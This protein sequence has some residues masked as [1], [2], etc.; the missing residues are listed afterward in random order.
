MGFESRF[1]STSESIIPIPR[2]TIPTITIIPETA[3]GMT[4]YIKGELGFVMACELCGSS[5]NIII[6][7]RGLSA[8]FL[9]TKL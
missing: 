7:E 4:V 3:S 8:L 6:T 1:Q 5:E 2:D 9:T